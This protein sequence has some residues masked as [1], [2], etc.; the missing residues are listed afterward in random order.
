[1]KYSISLL[2]FFSISFVATAQVTGIN[3][4]PFRRVI[5]EASVTGF[6]LDKYP[7]ITTGKNYYFYENS[8]HLALMTNMTKYLMF[9]FNYNYLWTKYKQETIDNY[10][11]AGLNIRYDRPIKNRFRLYGDIIADIGNYCNC[12]KDVRVD[13]MP[14]KIDNSFYYG[15]ALGLSIKVYKP[16]WI[17]LAFNSYVLINKKYDSYGYVQPVLGIQFHAF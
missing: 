3:N 9:G 16:I 2:I 6:P 10:F 17:N 8:I 5:F 13:N 12:I 15:L 11:F 4:S 14:F 7:D 1:M